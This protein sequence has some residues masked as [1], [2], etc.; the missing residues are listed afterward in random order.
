MFIDGCF[1]HGCPEHQ[2]VPKSNPDY[3]IPKLRRNSERDREVDAALED[4]GWTVLRLWEHEDPTQAAM[5]V[6]RV[7]RS[8][9]VGF[10]VPDRK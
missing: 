8:D 2:V 7:V 4:D 3:W 1:W 5:A 6:E 9:A 10:G